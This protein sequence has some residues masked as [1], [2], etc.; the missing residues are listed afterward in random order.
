MSLLWPHCLCLPM[1]ASA[2]VNAQVH[3]A[4]QPAEQATCSP[5]PCSVFT[6]G[7]VFHN[8]EL[9]STLQPRLSLADQ[10]T[11]VTGNMLKALAEGATDMA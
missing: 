1:T 4:L 6:W 8:H 9:P 10:N 5:A 7:Q 11:Q 3:H 2:V